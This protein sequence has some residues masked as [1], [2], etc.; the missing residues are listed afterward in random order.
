MTE[1]FNFSTIEK[2]KE[3]KRVIEVWATKKN[4]KRQKGQYDRPDV[5]NCHPWNLSRSLSTLP[6]ILSFMKFYEMGDSLT[7]FGRTSPWLS[8]RG[9]PC[10]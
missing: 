3:E 6:V 7:F 9:S 2:K 8:S 4:H 5:S 10:G 1:I